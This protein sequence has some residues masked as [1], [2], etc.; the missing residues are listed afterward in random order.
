MS[1][2]RRAV[3]RSRL[4]GVNTV[5]KRLADGTIRTYFYHRGSGLRLRG[6]P[7]TSEFIASY[8]AA[9]NARREDTSVTCSGVIRDFLKSAEF[10]NELAEST[11]REY[12]RILTLIENQF[13]N[14]PLG[15]IADPRFAGDVLACR[16][17]RRN[18]CKGFRR[19]RG[20]VRAVF[21]QAV[22]YVSWHG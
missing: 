13:G 10:N 20:A 15:A 14:A 16:T 9:D 3:V 21:F 17:S 4:P 11:Q 22:A 1:D 2:G 19:T 5:H 6:S 8:A 18:H 12:R 7:D